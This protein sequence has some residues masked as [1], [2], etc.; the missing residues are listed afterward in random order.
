MSN[1]NGNPRRDATP[2]VIPYKRV[3]IGAD[4][5][6]LQAELAELRRRAEIYPR[7]LPVVPSTGKRETG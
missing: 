1:R 4:L 2:V 3:A 7:S 6:R 5:E